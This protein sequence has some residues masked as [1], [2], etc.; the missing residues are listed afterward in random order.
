MAAIAEIFPERQIRGA[1]ILILVLLGTNPY[2]FERLAKAADAYA[3]QIE[4]EMFIQI[5]HTAYV[6]ENAAYQPFLDQEAL[7]QKI[8]TADLIITQGGFGSIA[9]C[10]MA[11]KKVV[12]VPRKPE[13]NEAPDVQE[14]LVR[15]LEKM[16]RLIGVYDI[17][18]LPQAVKKARQTDFKSGG[19]H[20]MAVLIKRFIAQN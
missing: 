8:K 3:A 10:L 16:G 20:R 15:Q 1:F 13:L 2:S 14:E 17:S 7:K 9:D 18:K 19:A 5:G 6:P 4:D 11:Q 12:A